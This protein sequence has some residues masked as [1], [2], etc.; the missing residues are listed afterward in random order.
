MK[1]LVVCQHYW[2]EQF[3][4]TAICEELVKRGHQVTVLAGLPNYPQGVIP[5]EYRGGK[6]RFQ[7]RDGVKIIRVGEIGRKQNALGLAINYYSYS[8]LASRKTKELADDF[9]VVFAYQLSP[10]MMASPAVA[11]KNRT[12]IP[13]LLYCCDLWPE[14]MKVM[15]GGRGKTIFNHYKTVSKKIY[16]SADVV[17]VQSL[18]FI[19]YFKQQHSMPEGRLVYVPQ[20]A[21][22][23][24]LD[25]DFS[26]AHEGVNFVFLGNIG[27]AQDIPCILN[28]VKYMSHNSGFKVHFVGDGA[29]LSEA[30]QLTEALALTEQVIFHGSKPFAEMPLYYRLADACLLTLDGCSW[31]GTTLPSKLQGYMAAGKPVIAAING[32]ARDVIEQSG[33]GRAVDA[34]DA[35]GLAQLMDDFV[36]N[37]NK[38]EACGNAGRNYFRTHF[39]RNKYI[40]D[41][42]RLLNRISEGEVHVQG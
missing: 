37:K 2:P 27:R 1:I 3:Q 18:S 25:A 32:G 34:G 16:H 13:L 5:L 28:A 8:L 21:T 14:S 23:K 11:Y 17:A 7:E 29:C 6:N 36:A 10:V 39:T 41:I 26:E 33:C 19:E 15:L 35:Q 30:Q 12:G 42:E 4:I 31:V 38:Y 20:F 9:D 22:S 24:Y 40:D